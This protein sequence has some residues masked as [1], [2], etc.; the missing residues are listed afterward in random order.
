ML[1]PAQL[2]EFETGIFN[3]LVVAALYVVVYKRRRA[4]PINKHILAVTVLMYL[5]AFAVR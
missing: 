5:V 4:Q 2:I 1:F 3:V